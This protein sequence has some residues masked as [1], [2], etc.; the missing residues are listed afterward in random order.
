MS[1]EKLKDLRVRWENQIKSTLNHLQEVYAAVLSHIKE[2]PECY[3][4]RCVKWKDETYM[5][6][7]LG[8]DI[9]FLTPDREHP[10]G[11][12]FQ[13]VFGMRVREFLLF[14][15]D[16]KASH[17]CVLKIIFGHSCSAVSAVVK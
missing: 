3:R 12:L 5:M 14:Q 7:D 10:R 8:S 16:A 15:G 1:V 17:E 13:T 9:Y 6:Y 11:K 2:H 4:R